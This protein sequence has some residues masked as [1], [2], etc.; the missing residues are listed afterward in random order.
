MLSNSI[1]LVADSRK[2]FNAILAHMIRAVVFDL[3][4]VF[5]P[6]TYTAWLNRHGLNRSGQFQAIVEQLDRGESTP[7]TFYTSLNELTGVP[8][9]EIE[10][11]FHTIPEVD[12]DVVSIVEKL[13]HRYSILLCSN[14][15]KRTRTLLEKT[16]LARLFQTVFI[17][18]EMGITKPNYLMFQ[19]IT[20]H[21]GLSVNEVLFI[22]DSSR[23]IDAAKKYGFHTIHYTTSDALRKSLV[24]YDFTV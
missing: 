3:Y 4:G 24:D 21:L 6:D 23:N 17:S 19:K 12:H 7:H 20:E 14:G 2:R 9:A 15:T 1:A 8:V 13:Q 18:A 16:D 10:Q 11:D 22:D 5:I